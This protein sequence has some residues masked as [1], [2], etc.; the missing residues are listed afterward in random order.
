MGLGRVAAL[1]RA[2]SLSPFLIPKAFLYGLIDCVSLCRSLSLS[3]AL[4]HLLLVETK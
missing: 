1:S 4:S 3:A 2:L